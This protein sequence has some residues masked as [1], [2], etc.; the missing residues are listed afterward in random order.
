MPIIDCNT[1]F[2]RIASGL[3]TECG[4]LAAVLGPCYPKHITISPLASRLGL[5]FF[6]PGT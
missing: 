4:V 6:L 5:I 1:V 2:A 3:G